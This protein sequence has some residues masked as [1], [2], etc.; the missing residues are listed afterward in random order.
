MINVR[1]NGVSFQQIPYTEGGEEVTVYWDEGNK[2]D[3]HAYGVKLEGL[4]IGW[5]PKVATLRAE[6]F[7]A[8]DGF[9]KVGA[10][11]WEF[12]G[13]DEMRKVYVA[14]N[15]E[16]NVVE[17]VRDNLYTDFTRNHCT[18][19]GKLSAGYWDD[20]EGYNYRALGEIRS[21]TITLDYQ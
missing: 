2:Y 3:N 9:K 13:K 12:V 18:P 10:D 6:A 1:L 16:A 7:K 4:H 14:K 5:I 19:K 8:R 21:L 20:V 17:Y 11:K 15:E